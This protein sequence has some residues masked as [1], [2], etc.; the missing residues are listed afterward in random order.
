MLPGYVLDI[1][2]KATNDPSIRYEY[3]MPVKHK[4]YGQAYW[5]WASRGDKCCHIWIDAEAT[6]VKRFVKNVKRYLYQPSKN[7]TNFSIP[8]KYKDSWK[9]EPIFKE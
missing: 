3:Q 6:L 5:F 2:N 1:L 9:N 8:A 4:Y 7:T